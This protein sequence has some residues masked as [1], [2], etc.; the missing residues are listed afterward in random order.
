MVASAIDPNERE[1]DFAGPSGPNV[2][3][4][5]TRKGIKS[6]RLVLRGALSE[7]AHEDEMNAAV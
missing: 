1:N 7:V 3:Q 6:E 4:W 5:L 2:L